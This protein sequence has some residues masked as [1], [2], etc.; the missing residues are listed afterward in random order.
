MSSISVTELDLLTFF[1]VMPTL[2]DP[3]DPW[4]YNDACYEVAQGEVALS[5]SIAPA[6]RDVRIVLKVGADVLYELNATGVE[7]V[8]YHNDSARESVEV[9]L[10]SQDRLLVWLKPRIN[11]LHEQNERA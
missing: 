9:V 8:K 3:E 6:Y 1:E 11:V 4:P 7:D 5:F 10:N 2:A